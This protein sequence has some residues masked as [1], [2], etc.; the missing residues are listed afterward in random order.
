MR[1]FALIPAAGSGA[2]VGATVPKQY[3]PVAG[4]P[5]I[6]HAIDALARAPSIGRVLVVLAP[7]DTLFDTAMVD[8]ALASRVDV[9]RCGGSTRHASVRHGLAALATHG[10]DAAADDDWV[11]VHDAARCGL[12]SAMVE[13]LVAALD[14]D[15]VGGLLAWPVADTLKRADEDGAH[16]TATV[17]RARLWQAQTPQ[18]F[19]YRLLVDALD[20][21]AASGLAVT[22]EASAIEA[23]GHRPRL[24][25]GSNRNFKVTT[26]DDL[27][28]M[29]ALMRG[30]SEGAAR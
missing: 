30:M 21:A 13:A 10:D 9:A 15:A 16:V 12:T 26:A 29:D 23:A 2:R 18:M 25:I 4:L 6:A 8:D 28:L 17:D 5:M 24:V 11:L 7:D 22:D 19:R 3:L 14:G 1:R 20:A 27:A